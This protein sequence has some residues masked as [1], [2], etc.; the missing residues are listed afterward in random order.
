MNKYRIVMENYGGG[1]KL[2][3]C[4]AASDREAQYKAMRYFDRGDYNWKVK[5]MA[6]EVAK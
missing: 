3:L 1:T 4:K 2:F 5:S 6:V